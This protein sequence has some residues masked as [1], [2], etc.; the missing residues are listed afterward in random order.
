MKEYIEYE[1]K[2]LVKKYNTRDPFKIANELNI[3]IKYYN[4]K[5]LKGFYTYCYKNRYIGINYN[6]SEIKQQLCCGHEIGHDQ[7]HRH[8]TYYMKDYDLFTTNSRTEYQANLMAAHIL[9]PDELLDKYYNSGYT[10][11]QIAAN[12]N[13]YPDLI[14][15]KFD[16]DIF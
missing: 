12:E 7:L 13:L 2:K 4:F 10:I 1:A 8:L 16:L 11:E 9:V 15:L 6:L 14:R 5:K 3:T